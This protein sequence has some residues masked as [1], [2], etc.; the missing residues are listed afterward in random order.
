[1]SVQNKLDN[2]RLSLN[3]KKEGCS[4]EELTVVL[5]KEKY[6]IKSTKFKYVAV[7]VNHGNQSKKIPP[8]KGKIFKPN[9]KNNLDIKPNVY[10]DGTF[11]A[12]RNMSFLQW[13]MSFLQ[14]IWTQEDRLLEAKG[15][16]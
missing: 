16:T 6:D 2:I 5:V 15:T 8:K 12:G 7:V 1:M 14:Q 4:L 10:N 9:M 13:K 3:S 11:L